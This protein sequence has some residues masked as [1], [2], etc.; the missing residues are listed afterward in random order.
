[1]FQSEPIDR[2][3]SPLPALLLLA[4]GASLGLVLHFLTWGPEPWQITQSAPRLGAAAALGAGG[5]VFAVS[6]DR[7]RRLWSLFLALGSGAVAGFVVGWNGS[8]DH[9]GAGEGWQLVAALLAIGIAVPIFQASRDS[10]RWNP[11]YAA[12]HAHGWTDAVLWAV[13]CGFTLL[14]WL[15][16]NLLGAL[17]DLIGIDLVGETIRQ[18]WFAW[19]ALCA[20]LGAA[21]GLLRERDWVLGLLQRVATA[22]LSVLSPVLAA[23]LVLFVLAL[24][25]TGLE[26][27][28]EQTRATTPILLA[29]TIGAIL[30]VNAAIGRDEEDES[31]SRAVRWAAAALAAITFP[32]ALVAAISTGKRIAQH[33]FTP[34][35]LW[36]TVFVAITVVGAAAYLF[37]L[38]RGRAGWP[39]L[40]RKAN[41]RLAIGTGLVALFLALPIVDFGAIST[42]DQVARLQSIRIAPDRFDWAALRFDFG[43]SGRRAL[44]ELARSPDPVIRQRAR[45]A[46]RAASRWAIASPEPAAPARSVRAPANLRVEGGKAVPAAL[47]DLVARDGQCAYGEACRLV[48]LTAGRA[49]LLH[50]GCRHC[51]PRLFDARPDDTW[52]QRLPPPPVTTSNGPLPDT[53]NG[54]VEV[55][56]VERQQ[57]FIDGRPVGDPFE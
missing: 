36:A 42:R 39:A 21:I 49:I 22:I 27:L 9:W 10:P 32:L 17:F 43:P 11:D 31:R 13:A 51:A 1:M 26:P 56:K 5:I 40:L 15:M 25:F 41:L 16:L 29:C 57:L 2:E 48:F 37:A 23:G 8:P 4:L 45:E 20:A 30:L 55:R 12:V 35:R 33:G 18:S 54:R 47:S 52:V 7:I 24:P 19:T 28:W 6:L 3:P 14:T 44:G 50:P 38:V 53:A 46:L 34:D